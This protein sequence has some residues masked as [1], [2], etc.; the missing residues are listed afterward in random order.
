MREDSVPKDA[1][2]E[3]VRQ[4]LALRDIIR[5][6]SLKGRIGSICKN[7]PAEKEKETAVFGKVLYSSSY[8]TYFH[9]TL[10]LQEAKT[11][12]HFFQEIYSTL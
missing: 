7:N 11:N 4:Y 6:L 3:E 12:S 2:D 8:H 9:Q 5:L 1:K 10:C